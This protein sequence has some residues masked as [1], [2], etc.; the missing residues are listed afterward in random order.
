[1]PTGFVSDAKKGLWIYKTPDGELAYTLDLADV[2]DPWLGLGETVTV[3]NFTV[4]DPGLTILA[5]TNSTTT[6]TVKLGGGVDGSDYRVTMEWTTSVP[7]ID[8]RYFTVKV[9]QR[10]AG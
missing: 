10:S 4:D 7:N 5:Q 1:M 9:R 2:A 3:C 6:G 8:S